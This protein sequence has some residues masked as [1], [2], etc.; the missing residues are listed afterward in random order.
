[1]IRMCAILEHLKLIPTSVDYLVQ[2]HRS[3]SRVSVWRRWHME[4][5]DYILNQIR[6]RWQDPESHRRHVRDHAPSEVVKS[7]NKEKAI[8][9]AAASNAIAGYNDHLDSSSPPTCNLLPWR[10]CWR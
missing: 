6:Q 5:T 2:R 9:A 7:T 10:R 8:A 3:N 1:M 4:S